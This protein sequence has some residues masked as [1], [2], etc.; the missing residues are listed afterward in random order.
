MIVPRKLAQTSG[1]HLYFLML[2]LPYFLATYLL[3]WMFLGVDTSGPQTSI[4]EEVLLSFYF[5]C[6]DVEGCMFPVVR[7]DTGKVPGQPQSCYK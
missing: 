6:G 1:L 7:N 4:T 5:I 3:A 2:F